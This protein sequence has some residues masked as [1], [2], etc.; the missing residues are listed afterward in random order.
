MAEI[1]DMGQYAGFVWAG[2]GLSALALAGLTA[3]VVIE[4]RKV[5]TRVKRAQE[6]MEQQAR[7]TA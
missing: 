6:R 4:R 3:F 1:L 5:Q 2:W 7:P